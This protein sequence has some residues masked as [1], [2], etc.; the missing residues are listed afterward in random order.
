MVIVNDDDDLYK[1]ILHPHDNYA[2]VISL[3][4]NEIF[5]QNEYAQERF[6][7]IMLSMFSLFQVHK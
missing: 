6:G 3:G 4:K 1:S 2:Q 7:N 5:S